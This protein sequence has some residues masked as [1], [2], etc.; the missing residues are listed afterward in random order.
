MLEIFKPDLG[1]APF[2]DSVKKSFVD[3][4]TAALKLNLMITLY[5]IFVDKGFIELFLYIAC[6]IVILGFNWKDVRHMYQDTKAKIQRA[7]KRL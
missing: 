1:I 5:Y 2:F 4:F 6:C 7:K 3:Y